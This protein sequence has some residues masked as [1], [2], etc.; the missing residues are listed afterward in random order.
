[1]YRLFNI[2]GFLIT[3]LFTGAAIA[4]DGEIDWRVFSAWCPSSPSVCIGSLD[5]KDSASLTD[6]VNPEYLETAS[7]S[8]VLSFSFSEI[9]Q[10]YQLL[11]SGGSVPELSRY[12]QG[13]QRDI[14]EREQLYRYAS[15]GVLESSVVFHHPELRHYHKE[16]RYLK[17][18]Q[19]INQQQLTLLKKTSID[20]ASINDE[21]LSALITQ[22][23]Q[24]TERLKRAVHTLASQ[25]NKDIDIE[26][27]VL[28]YF[29]LKQEGS[30]EQ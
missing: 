20:E 17:S 2:T 7:S 14:T 3:L 6:L 12:V 11:V 19:I 8:T 25:L 18:L 5:H 13:M 30:G 9:G 29:T 22:I 1:M 27:Q 23:D 21:A 26:K 24:Q 15:K 4:K 16:L 10:A 28:R